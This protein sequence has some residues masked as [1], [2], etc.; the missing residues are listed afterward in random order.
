MFPF[1]PQPLTMGNVPQH[2]KSIS[3]PATRT[4]PIRL[5]TTIITILPQQTSIP[6]RLLN[7]QNSNSLINPS[8]LQYDTTYAPN[9]KNDS[10]IDLYTDTNDV[11][12]G[13]ENTDE[14][15]GTQNEYRH[16]WQHVKKRKRIQQN[17]ES[18]TRTNPEISTQNRYTPLLNKQENE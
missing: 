2:S 4:C 1:P 17:I 13:K 10:D 9:S 18:S 11:D 12:N 6:T 16:G 15:K 7:Q 14:N 5:S 8:H 3:Y